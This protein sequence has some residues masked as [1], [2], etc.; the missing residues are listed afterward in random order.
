MESYLPSF[1]AGTIQ[2]I[3]RSLTT[4]QTSNLNCTCNVSMAYKIAYALCPFD[5]VI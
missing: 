3:R 5:T 4:F 2:H 1:K